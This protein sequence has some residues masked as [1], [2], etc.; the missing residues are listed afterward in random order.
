M[1]TNDVSE[2]DFS[3]GLD[4]VYHDGQTIS[5]DY[6]E[7]TV[8]SN[9]SVFVFGNC[10]LVINDAHMFTFRGPCSS[11]A[12]LNNIILKLNE[13]LSV[14]FCTMIGCG[15]YGDVVLAAAAAAA[16]AVAPWTISMIINPDYLGYMGMDL[17]KIRERNK[18]GTHLFYVLQ[19]RKDLT[20]YDKFFNGPMKGLFN[21]NLIQGW[22]Y[23]IPSKSF[24]DDSQINQH[25]VSLSSADLLAFIEYMSF[26]K[27]DSE[28]LGLYKIYR[29]Y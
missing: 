1:D 29:E 17:S 8:S 22:S 12:A 9:R 2:L 14:Q 5:L 28:A 16:V 6:K 21:T 18:S 25:A 15:A 7:C 27:K 19:N 23:Q 20:H 11:V 3:N 24:Y 10:P 13:L 26:N 4:I